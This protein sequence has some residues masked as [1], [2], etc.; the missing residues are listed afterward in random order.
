MFILFTFFLPL[1]ACSQR[2]VSA[3]DFAIPSS[4]VGILNT[5]VAE[6]ETSPDLEVDNQEILAEEGSK[7]E[8]SSG[9]TGVDYSIYSHFEEILALLPQEY[10]HPF[11]LESIGRGIIEKE[12]DSIQ[13]ILVYVGQVTND[14]IAADMAAILS[15]ES[16]YLEQSLSDSPAREMETTT[17]SYHVQMIEE[18]H[19]YGELIPDD[20]AATAVYIQVAGMGGRDIAKWFDDFTFSYEDYQLPDVLLNSL[21]PTRK[22]VA[23]LNN[24]EPGKDFL[25]SMS[26]WGQLTLQDGYH[27]LR[28]LRST[29]CGKRI[30]FP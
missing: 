14:Q 22:S 24:V 8:S 2:T 27:H 16:S 12:N 9:K 23:V 21:P 1:T 20:T 3:E 30:S 5:S 19:W 10:T 11:P 13:I 7:K 18:E 15:V 29:L 28:T 17:A 4:R 26:E 25:F 6:L